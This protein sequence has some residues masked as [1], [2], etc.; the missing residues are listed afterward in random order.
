[1]K[2]KRSIVIEVPNDKLQFNESDYEKK[3]D[4]STDCISRIQVMCNI[5]NNHKS[6]LINYYCI[7][8]EH[9]KYAKEFYK[10]NNKGN[11][12]KFFD[13]MAKLINYSRTHINF[14]I[15]IS[16]L[17]KL[18]PKFKLVCMPTDEIKDNMTDLEPQMKKD[19]EFWNN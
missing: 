1:M 10:N 9:F 18:Y 3:P 14:L 7:V 11:L 13:D 15:R 16:K 5:I 8:G 4:N 12:D 17:C 19:S 6:K 2:L